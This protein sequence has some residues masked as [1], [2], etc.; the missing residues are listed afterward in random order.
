MNHA[1]APRPPARVWLPVALLVGFLA[2]ILFL[3]SGLS[4]P[5]VLEAGSRDRA[6]APVFNAPG[7]NSKRL[8][9]QNNGLPLGFE[10]KQRQTLQDPTLASAASPLFIEN[11]GQFPDA[12][13][14]R[15]W[16]AGPAAWLSDDAIWF[17]AASGAANKDPVD[18]TTRQ[19]CDTSPRPSLACWSGS[20]FAA[21]IKLSFPG[22]NPH[23]RLEPFDRLKTHVS[24]FA[25]SD[26]A[27]WRTDV[28]V[29]GGVRYRD[30][31]PGIDLEVTAENGRLAPRL[32][33]A[34]GAD[35][36]VVSLRMEGADSV[37]VRGGEMR[38]RWAA[39][40]VSV[41]LL[42]AVST[43]GSVLPTSVSEPRV[44]AAT[45]GGDGAGATDISDPFV[46]P[47]AA[48]PAEV[49]ASEVLTG[50]ADLIYSTY[51]G[52]DDDDRSWNYNG[53]AVDASGS[54]Y[55]AG[56]TYSSNFPTTPGSYNPIFRG[57]IAAA[58]VVKFDP[59]GSSLAY[60]TF[61][62]GKGS[63]YGE[64][65]AVD[66]TGAAYVAWYGQAS[67]A[68]ITHSVPED[69]AADTGD[70]V[71]VSKLDPT[72]SALLYSLRV[73]GSDAEFA[74]GLA[75]GA[76]GAA[77][78]TGYTYSSNFPT[79]GG[80]DTSLGGG[81]DAFAI[82][83]KPDG[84]GLLYGTFLGGSKGEWG[85]HIAVDG[86]G[87]AYVT[88][89]T[90]SGDF[91]TTGG[92][93]D[94][95]YGGGDSGDA[96]VAKL[97]PSGSALVYSTYL[98]GNSIEHGEGIALGSDGMAY[99]TGQTASADFPTTTGAFSRICGGCNPVGGTGDVYVAKLNA[100]GSALVYSTFLG[101]SR[102]NF[103][104]YGTSIAVNPW[105]VAYVTGW[106]QNADFPV[107]A[108]AYD[109]TQ[110]SVWGGDWN[111]YDAFVTLLNAS[112]SAL[113]YSTFLGGY[114]NDHGYAIAIGPDGAAYVRGY[115]SSAD[116]PTTAG[117]FDRT[118]NGGDDS[119][120]AKLLPANIGRPRPTATPTRTRTPTNTPTP[121]STFTPTPTATPPLPD[122]IAD[123]LEVT[124]AIQDLNNS[125]RLAANK[126]TYVR[127]H[128]HST[129][130]EYSTDAQ[131]RVRK[132][133][134]EIVLTTDSR[135]V[136]PVPDRSMYTH[137]FLFAL[138]DGYRD[139][140]VS[141]TAEVNPVNAWRTRSPIEASYDNNT[142]SANVTFETVPP[143]NVVIY[144]VGY[145]VGGRTYSAPPSH[146]Y[147]L[148]D[149]LRRAYPVNTVSSTYRT[150]D[151]GSSLP[152]CNDVNSSLS[153]KR[154]WDRLFSSIP[155]TAH[156]Y[157]MVDDG[158][159]FMRG[160]AAGIPALVAAGPTGTGNWGWDFDG[161]Y[162]DWYGGH[163][164][165]HSYG[166]RHVL[167]SGS[168]D[169][170]N[171]AY[172][173]AGGT[174]SSVRQ[175]KAAF[176]GFDI[177][178]FDIYGPTW[179][180]IMTYCK[181]QWMSQFTYE[182]LMSFLQTNTQEATVASLDRADRLL[183]V[184]S[185]QPD[186]MQVDLQPVFMIPNV[187][188]V[189]PRTPGPYA[190]VLRG[191]SGELAR[192]PF[193]PTVLQQ[194]PALN[195][196]DTFS[197]AQILTID[198]LV[199][200]V[201]G[202]TRLDIEGPGGTVIKTIT[203]GLATPT[204]NVTQPAGGAILAGD[205]IPV[206]WTANDPD[207]DPL[208]FNVQYSPDG[209]AT[210]EVVAQNLHGTHA[211]LDA[212]NF[213]RS[214]GQNGLIR[215][216][217]S[218]GIQTGQGQS[219]AF[220]VPNRPPT[221]EILA[222]ADGVTVAAGQAVAF[223]GRALDPDLGTV[224]EDQVQWS[225]DRDGVLGHGA[226]INVA[227]LSV[228]THIVTFHADDGA[229]GV[230]SRSVH[231]TVVSSP[232]QL[233]PPTDDLV[234][235]PSS[236]LLD[237]GQGINSV[238]LYIENANASYVIGWNA[239]V[240]ESW[241]R[242]S[243]TTG[244][245]PAQVMVTSNRAD[246]SDGTYTAVI[247]LT[248]PALPGATVSI[249]V[250][251]ILT[252][253]STYLP[254]ILRNYTVPPPTTGTPTRTPG[255][256]GSPTPT[257]TWTAT[258]TRT[259]MPMAT[260][261]PTP[262][263][264][265]TPT[266]THTSMPTATGSPTPAATSTPTPTRTITPVAT[267]S[268][269]P[270]ATWTPTST[271]TPTPTPSA[272]L[273]P[274]ATGTTASECTQRDDFASPALDPSWGWVREDP[275]HWSLTAL[276]G[277]LRI[278]TQE[279]DIFAATND[280]HNLLLRNGPA[281]DFEISAAV[282]FA[283]SANYQQA[284]LLVYWDDQN[285][286]SIKRIFSTVSG[287]NG[288]EFNW[289]VGGNFYFLARSETATDL[290]LKLTKAGTTYT[291]LYSI[292]GQIWTQVGQISLANAA[293]PRVGLG[294]WNGAATA[295]EIPADFDWFCL[296]G[297]AP[298]AT[299][300]RT[301][302]ATPTPTVTPAPAWQTIFADGFEGSFPGAWQRLGNPGWGRTNCKS[303]AGTYSVWPAAAGTGAVTPCTNNY[304]PNLNAWLIY[305]PFS[306]TGA[307]AAEMT[308][309]RWQR[310]EDGYDT[311]TWLASVDGQHFYGVTDSGDTGGWVAETLDLSD[312][313]TLGDLRGQP[314]VWIAFLF[315]SDADTNDLGAFVDDVVIRKQTGT[316]AAS[317]PDTQFPSRRDLKPASAL[318][319]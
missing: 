10:P 252:R 56:Y 37:E 126:P 190:I 136:R 75:L 107:T 70:D 241:V 17:T 281:G 260:G 179:T 50:T 300:T 258:P 76:G 160:C 187:E 44:S 272:T 92:A 143:L 225:S 133:S 31:Y 144:R 319:P 318:R 183:V 61:L 103:D 134:D 101:G 139:G 82:K 220:T 146:A 280:A 28:P 7:P 302:T 206:S 203:S 52:G 278:T 188:D 58:F 68:P 261:S 249:P 27:G 85:G 294:A 216:W 122:L 285:W 271:R 15:V 114:G 227:K 198:E 269:T 95:S 73:A 127:F 34:P 53:L 270:T 251:L 194:D 233:P 96:F 317:R 313:F 51:L 117:A 297:G 54:A 26:P 40:E 292:D 121:T 186:S 111:G 295:A 230:A 217:A 59:T 309:Q 274:T 155:A 312:I 104:D 132:G 115:T 109:T 112:G 57:D 240:S 90:F 30:L 99:V 223:E 141:L 246:L 299:P 63:Y 5:K 268:P 289:E 20:Q 201:A 237:P 218:G 248:S 105:G 301:P 185:I 8:I 83:V 178:S 108:D 204:V 77:Y 84:T 222:P 19:E 253:R 171:P 55:V 106:T 135:I 100:T 164:L 199:P 142:S 138:P 36:S 110:N 71:F 94:R 119:F 245:T 244:S 80:F 145:E 39:G 284:H 60:A 102:S 79:P 131:L 41:P 191:A 169:G 74:K 250:Q 182:N 43:A 98:G 235:G 91:P 234:V 168:E 64:G 277:Y 45:G 165:G 273:T 12:A 316:Q 166:Q 193:T 310:S 118:A 130:G 128:V 49:H 153:S 157:G 214:Q 298:V 306:L 243:A 231:V 175:G 283:P 263:A 232:R 236:I 22:A 197:P 148:S 167:C 69:A 287:G 208:T 120:V 1:G 200:Y 3:I 4:G 259:S 293:I 156:Y 215:V 282:K 265:S 65:I 129:Y 174:I 267:G 308:F 66:A 89:T 154:L 78:V 275:T 209:G 288:V 149:W 9:A 264:T 202:T 151:I 14:F 224:P 172:P 97:N 314:Q 93:F 311:L 159:G 21:N 32:V 239:V 46:V 158:G 16:G 25:G 62:G 247:N 86:N 152:S 255:A 228:G 229:G 125:V 147:Q 24:Y 276:P 212:S 307:T 2:P 286:V 124:Q 137:S 88:G 210:W 196:R 221:V 296:N 150:M 256:A 207:G 173:F 6:A 266:P 163:E 162:G 262:S 195:E 35:L 33:V 116:F 254:L 211:D 219:A 113:V 170:A 305:G 42:T 29:W 18:Q 161:S 177:G 176:Y 205:T 303:Y 180:D 257:A 192:Y 213:T 181:F 72:G 67:Q 238:T 38:V 13:R 47:P 315:Q 291:G 189:K 279:G 184:G 48:P 81:Q 140:S 123:G 304:P 226:H 87:A 290:Q 11:A 23:P 242:L